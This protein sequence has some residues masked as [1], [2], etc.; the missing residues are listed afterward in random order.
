MKYLLTLLLFISNIAYAEFK[1]D[2]IPNDTTLAQRGFEKQDEAKAKE[3]LLKIISKSQWMKGEFNSEVSDL[4][5]TEKDMEGNDVV[6]YYHPSNFTYTIT[7]ITQEIADK[8]A[9]K[10]EKKA[11]KQQAKNIK[12]L[13]KKWSELNDNQ[14][15]RLIKY[16]IRNL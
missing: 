9:E 6:T 11:E 13:K 7:D 12:N 14:K 4:S 8:E 2:I 1:V 5:K 3:H 15:D 16:L 10:A